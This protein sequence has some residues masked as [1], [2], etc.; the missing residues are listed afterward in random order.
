MH[1]RP[2]PSRARPTRSRLGSASLALLAVLALSPEAMAQGLRG[3]TAPAQG[4]APRRAEPPALPGLQG[5]RPAPAIPAD[6]SLGNLSPNES[7]FDAINR[8]DLPAAREAVGRGASIDAQNVLGLT[9]IDSAVDQGRTDILFYLLSVRGS[10]RGGS[11]P[12]PGAEPP[13]P[14]RPGRRGPARE[15]ARV[16]PEGP[17]PVRP[18]PVA[19]PRLFAGDGGA[20]I[21]SIGFLGFDAGRPAGAVPLLEAR[22]SRPRGRG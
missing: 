18:T 12:P 9:P 3:P 5:R 4:V 22:P 1:P 17:A 6:P 16:E 13:P 10:A 7:L 8:G 2:V 19:R 11:G 20:P 15:A 14:A 21:P